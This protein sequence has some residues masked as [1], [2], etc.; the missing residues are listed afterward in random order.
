[1]TV[2]DGEPLDPYGLLRAL[3]ARVDGHVE[4]SVFGE[5]DLA[6]ADALLARIDEVARSSPCDV[7]LDLLHLEFLGSTGIG[8]LI[9]AHEALACDGRRLVLR[10]VNGAPR[11]SLELTRMLERLNIAPG[12]AEA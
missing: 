12:T 7:H 4:I 3:V 6:S 5:L 10:N 2:A 11:R 8:A 9:S 1:M